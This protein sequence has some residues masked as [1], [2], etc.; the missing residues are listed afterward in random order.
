MYRCGLR[1]RWRDRSGCD[2]NEWRSP[3]SQQKNGTFK[4]VTKSAGITNESNSSLEDL[5]PTFI[6]YD[7]DGDVD[8]YVTHVVNRLAGQSPPI[9]PQKPLPAEASCG[10]ITGTALSLMLL[11]RLDSV[12]LDL[13]P[14]AV[15]TDY[16]NDRAVDLMVTGTEHHGP[17]KPKR[18]K[19]SRQPSVGL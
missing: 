19:I 1:Q 3:S 5:G 12:S 14:A 7:H 9:V 2:F 10:A 15:G 13:E 8:L 16:N 17:G 4:D 18:R 6:D 11:S